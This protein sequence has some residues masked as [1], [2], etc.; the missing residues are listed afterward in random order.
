MEL[1]LRHKYQDSFLWQ[2]VYEELLTASSVCNTWLW[3]VDSLLH[4]F[5]SAVP[6]H[7]KAIV[8]FKF[9]GTLMAKGHLEVKGL[10]E[11][12]LIVFGL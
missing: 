1:G 5:C 11:N 10:R 4:A 9:P 3:P 8:Q 7:N 6:T 12:F 2:C